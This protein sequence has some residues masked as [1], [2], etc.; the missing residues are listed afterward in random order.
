VAAALGAEFRRMHPTARRQPASDSL[1]DFF[2]AVHEL[3]V[4]RAVLCLSGGGIRSASFALGV[5]QALASGGFLGKFHYLSTV[6]GGG[7][8]GGW[9][10]AWRHHANNDAAV[11]ES[12]GTRRPQAQD[13]APRSGKGVPDPFAEPEELHGLREN[14]N[15]LTPKLGVLSADTWTIAALCGR[16][17]LLN[18]T[19]FGPFLLALVL[20]PRGSSLFLGWVHPHYDHLRHPFLRSAPLWLHW[21]GIPPILL[22]PAFL[23]LAGTT[24]S[25]LSHRRDFLVRP[26]PKVREAELREPRRSAEQS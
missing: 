13:G 22:C 24:A 6:S 16:N 9:L 10:S 26:L 2:A 15:F 20:V 25:F 1:E 8:V 17:L 5:L 18:W 3:P 19:I 7:Y 12:L 23:A 14:S 21:R 4:A 11:F